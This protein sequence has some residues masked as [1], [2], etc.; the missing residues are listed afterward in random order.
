MLVFFEGEDYQYGATLADIGDLQSDYL[1]DLIPQLS[2]SGTLELYEFGEDFPTLDELVGSEIFRSEYMD[3]LLEEG[4][5]FGGKGYSRTGFRD[6][7]NKKGIIFMI[8]LKI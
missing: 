6:F 3:D 8:F 7:V 5:I 1:S 2:G 4:N